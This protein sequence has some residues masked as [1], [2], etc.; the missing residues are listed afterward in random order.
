VPDGVSEPF[1]LDHCRNLRPVRVVER[2]SP[3]DMP[4]WEPLETAIRRSFRMER[5]DSSGLWCWRFFSSLRTLESKAC[6][7]LQGLLVQLN[8]AASLVGPPRFLYLDKPTTLECLQS[9][10]AV[11]RTKRSAGQP[12][13]DGR[14]SCPGW[15]RISPCTGCYMRRV[16]RS[17]GCRAVSTGAVDRLA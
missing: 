13:L 14:Q 6:L 8:L 5:A 3:G 16:N 7:P 2:G 10:S 15:N 11:Q 12:M 9:A 4:D 17:I 1:T